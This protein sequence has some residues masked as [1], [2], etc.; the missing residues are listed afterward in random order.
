M[1]GWLFRSVLQSQVRAFSTKIWRHV[2]FFLSPRGTSGKRT[3]ER[4]PRSPDSCLEPLNRK[5]KKPKDL[6]RTKMF[7]PSFPHLCPSQI[8]GR[9]FN[10]PIRVERL[11]GWASG[12]R[13]PRN[14]LCGRPKRAQCKRTRR[15]DRAEVRPDSLRGFSRLAASRIRPRPPA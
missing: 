8:Y 4:I 5:A 2:F 14:R 3:E 6:G 1:G 10:S 7:F 9:A 12:G 15:V 11:A 13:P